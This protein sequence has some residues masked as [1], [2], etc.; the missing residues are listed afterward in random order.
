MRR[1]ALHLTGVVA[2]A[3]AL[4]AAGGQAAPVTSLRVMTY[5]IWVGGT[6]AGQPLSRTADVIQAAQ[7]DVVGLQEQSG[8][9]PALASMLGFHYWTSGGSTAIL[10][11]YPIVES[12]SQGAKIELS[13]TQQA[14][15]FD[16]HFAAYPYQPYDFRDGIITTEAQAIAAAQATRGGSVNGLLAGMSPAVAS[17]LPVFLTGDFNEPS[18][19]DWTV[20]AAAAG[21][22]FGK[23]V[24][25][26]TSR[27]VVGA[28]L[29]D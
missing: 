10:S 15:V 23:K 16:I 20:E 7:A 8:N 5:N 27:A 9:A 22:N 2:V 25:W 4:C 18:H 12:F 6:A 3:V 26:P 14:Y 19:L 1:I 21:L 28:G 29:A 13:P 24:E 17:G 11:R